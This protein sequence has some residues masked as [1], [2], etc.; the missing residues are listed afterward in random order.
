MDLLF[1]NSVLEL[2]LKKLEKERKEKEEVLDVL[3]EVNNVLHISEEKVTPDVLVEGES[4]V[5]NL[6]K[7]SQSESS[8]SE[9]GSQSKSS[10]IVEVKKFCSIGTQTDDFSSSDDVIEGLVSYRKLIIQDVQIYQTPKDYNKNKNK[11]KMKKVWMPKVQV[12]NAREKVQKAKVKNVQRKFYSYFPSDKDV[13]CW[14][15]ENREFGWFNEIYGN[16][17][18]PTKKRVLFSEDDRFSSNKWVCKKPTS[19]LNLK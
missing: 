1:C 15:K 13:R 5:S 6:S 8:C 2:G 9:A 16:F 19:I 7:V 4:K 18:F 17:C 10:K 11:S 3:D 12:P 14:R